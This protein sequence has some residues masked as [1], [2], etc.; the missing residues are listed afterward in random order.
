[1]SESSVWLLPNAARN[2]FSL[3]IFQAKA[4]D[5]K[6]PNLLLGPNRDDP[7]RRAVKVSRK[8]SSKP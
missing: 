4:P 7:S 1:M 3:A 2:H 8:R 5:G 6:K